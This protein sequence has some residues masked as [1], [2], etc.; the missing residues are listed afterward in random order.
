VPVLA[1][2]AVAASSSSP[3]VVVSTLFLLL[4]LGILGQ[5]LLP[6]LDQ[7]LGQ[8]H[9]FVVSTRLPTV[10]ATHL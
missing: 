9:H 1:V 4:L 2:V 6:G 3:S 5:G 7:G 8:G 10:E